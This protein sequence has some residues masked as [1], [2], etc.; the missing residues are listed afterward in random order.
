ME[1]ATTNVTGDSCFRRWLECLGTGITSNEMCIILLFIVQW[2]ELARV[3]NHC[4]PLLPQLLGVKNSLKN[5]AKTKYTSGN[6][7]YQK[8]TPF[9][10]T[11]KNTIQT[12][13]NSRVWC[14]PLWYVSKKIVSARERETRVCSTLLLGV[15]AVGGNRS[16]VERKKSRKA[17]LL[18]IRFFQNN[19]TL[20]LKTS[21]DT[22]CGLPHSHF[23]SG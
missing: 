18:K 17:N 22:L 16:K 12:P 11:S 3:L 2:S 7:H 6:F 10:A 1:P 15:P 4:K 5:A 23:F 9:S 14:Y 21:V 13:A 19:I 20:N 8:L